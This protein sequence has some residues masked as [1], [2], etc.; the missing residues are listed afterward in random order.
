MQMSNPFVNRVRELE[1]FDGILAS[2][3]AELV[4]LYGRRRVGKTA[5]LRQAAARVAEQV[6]AIAA[7]SR[8]PEPGS[9]S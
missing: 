6:Y 9:L 5:F 1:F 3:R 7:G 4:L 8:K 2:G